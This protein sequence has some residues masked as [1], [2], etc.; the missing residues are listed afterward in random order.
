M[1]GPLSSLHDILET[2]NLEGVM[3]SEHAANGE[4]ARITGAIRLDDF[5]MFGCL[6]NN[7][8]SFLFHHSLRNK[9]ILDQRRRKSEEQKEREGGQLHKREDEEH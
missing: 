1:K 8:K 4:P 7:H 9:Q 3:M 5:Q 2:Y 6:H